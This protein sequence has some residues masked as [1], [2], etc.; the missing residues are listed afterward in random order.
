[1]A[2][3][4]A[5]QQQGVMDGSAVPADKADGREVCG[6]KTSLLAS[7]EAGVAWDSGDVVYLGKQP[8]GTKITDIKVNTGTS[9][10]SATIAIGT[11]GDPRNGGTV[12]SAAA[13][14]AATTHTVVDKP[15]S[16]GP[17]ASVADDAP[18][19]EPVHLWATIAA[20]NIAAATVATIE[21]EF[22]GLS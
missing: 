2:T 5:I 17:K 1:M 4:Y 3:K 15:T 12:T 20:A 16:L 18:S 10:G 9:F 21:I 7:K 19:E 14:V 13:L 11:G 6:A 8:A 22:S